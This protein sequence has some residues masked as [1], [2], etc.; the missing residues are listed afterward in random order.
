VTGRAEQAVPRTLAITWEQHRRTRELCDWLGLPLHEVTVNAS[1]LR[2][3]IKLSGRTLRLLSQHRPK[4]LYVQN[5]SLILATLVLAARPFLGRYKVIVDAHNEAVAPFTHAYWPITSLSR[6]ALRAA[7]VTIVT[8]AALAEQVKEVGGSPHVL[9][10]RL[11]TPPLAPTEPPQL[12]GALRVMVVATYAADEP[13]AEIIE[14][15]RML[16]DQ[17]QLSIT[18]RETKLPADQRARLPA[19]VRQTG[20]LSEEAYWEL[21]RDSHITLDLTLKPNCLVC[22][23]YES[24]AALRPMVLTGNPAT[25]DLFGQVALFPDE[26]DAKSIAECLQRSRQQLAQLNNSVVTE[27]PRFEQ[28][29]LEHAYRLREKIANWVA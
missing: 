15:A 29:W 1:R 10:D 14:A 4:V 25:V 28:R 18:G 8:N 19:N 17:Y 5:P 9:P 20:F 2:R 26:H 24:L 12:D 16:G 7:D 3:Y 27:R 21:M 23:A 6:R 22:G 13:I 11:P